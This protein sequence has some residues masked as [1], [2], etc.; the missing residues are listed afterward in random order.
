MNE[1]EIGLQ[2]LAEIRAA[3][4]SLPAKPQIT[5][6]S[7]RN[8]RLAVEVRLPDGSMLSLYYSGKDKS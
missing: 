1:Q 8:A 4:E 2:V 5:E 7:I 6:V 3:I